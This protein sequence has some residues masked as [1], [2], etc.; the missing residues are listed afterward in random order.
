MSDRYVIIVEH[1]PVPQPRQRATATK[2]G[3]VVNYVP[4]NHP[5]RDFKDAI[6]RAAMEVVDGFVE[7]PIHMGITFVVPRP[8]S[9]T[10]EAKTEGRVPLTK[11]KGDWDNFGK[12]VSDALEGIFYANDCQIY[13]AYVEKYYSAEGESPHTIVLVEHSSPVEAPESP[14]NEPE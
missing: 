12:A 6:K 13:S 3:K 8:K 14:S 4:G 5:I 10:R 1:T 9:L 2:T 11:A 7:P